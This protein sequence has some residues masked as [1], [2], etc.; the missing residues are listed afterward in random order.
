[1]DNLSPLGVSFKKTIQF[2]GKLFTTSFLQATVAGPIQ[3]I[4]FLR[5]F[6]VL[7]LVT[8]CSL[9]T[10]SVIE[11]LNQMATEKCGAQQLST[12]VTS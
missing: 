1:M 4:D 5:K 8:L 11:Y 7:C 12:H 6:K 10:S 2:Q 3:G 9:F